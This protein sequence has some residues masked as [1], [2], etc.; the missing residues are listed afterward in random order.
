[1]DTGNRKF[2]VALVVATGA[3]SAGQWPVALGA[4]FIYTAA[5]VILKLNDKAPEAAE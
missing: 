5:N 4:L 1:M 2:G 3:I